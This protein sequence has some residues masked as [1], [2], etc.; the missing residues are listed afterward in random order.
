[1]YVCTA[2]YYRPVEIDP[3][4]WFSNT[5]VARTSRSVSR[6][7]SQRQ[8]LLLMTIAT[9]TVACVV[10]GITQKI[11][12]FW[13]KTLRSQ[14]QR[15]LSVVKCKKRL[16]INIPEETEYGPVSCDY[17][18]LALSPIHRIFDAHA[19]HD[20]A[21]EQPGSM[22]TTTS[23]AVRTDSTTMDKRALA[24]LALSEV[25]LTIDIAPSL[26]SQCEEDAI[27]ELSDLLERW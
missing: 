7:P 11:L 15:A 20:S 3:W 22:R 14:H 23:E 18:S 19:K 16:V 1:M 17:G 10:Q 9:M 21:K 24:N 26:H 2:E 4:Q 25:I 5:V 27:I 13:K 8:N 12:K 6:G